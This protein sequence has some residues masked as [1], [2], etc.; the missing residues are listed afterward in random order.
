MPELVNIAMPDLAK[1]R[2]GFDGQE[3]GLFNEFAVDRHTFYP[4][5]DP[6][7]KLST[8][9]STRRMTRRGT[10]QPDNDQRREPQHTLGERRGARTAVH[11]QVTAELEQV[12]FYEWVYRGVYDA[13]GQMER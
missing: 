2:P 7:G 8:V 5:D 1:T 6:Y 11:Q 12:L 3:H 9:D 4:G 13:A 10:T